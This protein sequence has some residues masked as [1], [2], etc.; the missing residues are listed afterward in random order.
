MELIAL[1]VH[2]AAALLLSLHVI[3]SRGSRYWL[4]ALFLVPLLAS[5]AYFLTVFIP[6]IRFERRVR[7][8]VATA[9]AP[10][11]K[12]ARPTAPTRREQALSAYEE[13]PSLDNRLRLAEAL[14]AEGAV[15]EGLRHY[16][17]C[18]AGPFGDDPAVRLSAIRAGMT[19]INA[20][21]PARV[22]LQLARNP[23]SSLFARA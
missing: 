2:I 22:G 20:Q 9:S 10:A 5:L 18:L 13:V 15:E 12:P 16:E 8:L 6:E 14:V 1:I 11:P 4:P 17:D 3:A 19:M 21:A 23:S 7:R